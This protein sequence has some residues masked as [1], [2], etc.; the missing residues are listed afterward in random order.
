MIHCKT[1][2]C[3]PS[4]DFYWNKRATYKI[5]ESEIVKQEVQ[6]S[7]A[8]IIEK[9]L[10]ECFN[11]PDIFKLSTEFLNTENWQ[12]EQ[13]FDFENG[14]YKSKDAIDDIISDLSDNNLI[15]VKLIKMGINVAAIPYKWQNL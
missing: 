8:A 10:K 11:F 4:S 12:L 6:I 3:N 13:F 7:I 2:H 1:I 5:K 15:K 14:K 9:K